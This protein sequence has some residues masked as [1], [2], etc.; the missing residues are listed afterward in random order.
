MYHWFVRPRWF[1]KKYI[2]DHI[3]S[4]VCL[5][6]KLILD[7][8]SGTGANCSIC[9][10][11]FYLGIEPD[12]SRVTLAK[13]LYPN[14]NFMI[15][16]GK[17]ISA[18]DETFDYIFIIAVLHHI[19][20]DQIKDYLLEFKR[21]LKPGGKVIVMEPCLCDRTKWNNRFMQWYDDGEY[22]R[23][24]DS[25]LSLFQAGQF[26]C[27]IL[28]KFTKCFVYNEIFFSA[29]LKDELESISYSAEFFNPPLE[30]GDFCDSRV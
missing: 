4:H 28:K 16:D 7:F 27:Q 25:Y 3:D 5:D 20:D 21:V 17:Q 29:T 1:T 10:P 6:N 19:A 8:G 9:K 15:F 13:R 2:H 14:H 18:Q 22:I 23:N 30:G 12:V 24:E 26:E 11:G